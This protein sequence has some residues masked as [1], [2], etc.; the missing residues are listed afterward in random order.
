MTGVL[1]MWNQSFRVVIF[2]WLIYVAY[3]VGYGLSIK[4]KWWTNYFNAILTS[5]ILSLILG[6]TYGTY[7]EDS[8]P[9]LGGGSVI[10]GF[11]PSKNERVEHVAFVF[12]ILGLP[13]SIGV[14][15]KKYDVAHNRAQREEGSE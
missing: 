14:Y 11:H 4:D 10:E 9:L 12:L 15:K 2:L 7:V 6:F 5:L 3:K 13:A 1:L 8:D